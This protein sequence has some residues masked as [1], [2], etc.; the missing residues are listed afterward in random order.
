MSVFLDVTKRISMKKLLTL[1]IV[2]TFTS[3]SSIFI[4]S[5]LKRKGIFDVKSELKIIKNEKQKIVFM[6][7]HHIGRKEFY[8]DVSKKIDSL[9]KL[10]YTVFY[11]S[12]SD[13]DK[14]DSITAVRSAMKLR[15]LMGFFPG[16]YLDTSTNVI[17]GKIKYRGKYKLINQPRYTEL[18][19]DGISSIRAD[20]G[21]S[22]L[23]TEFEKNN[24]K[25]KL[26]SCD[27]NV[28]LK[29]KEYKCKKVPKRLL[30]EFKKKYIFDYRNKHLAKKIIE[31]KKKKV[32]VVYG[33]AHYFGLYMKLFS[34]DK[35]YKINIR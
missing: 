30:K 18:N 11:E 5:A 2:L 10:N 9:Q 17:A 33:K 28:D 6:G 16:K 12:V 26:D 14:T 1:L 13:G 29:S 27:Y 31:S 24:G 34:L 3:C 32:L 25:I 15:K 20:V 8:D 35:S 22:E 19:V 23:I 4:N 7:M 21:I